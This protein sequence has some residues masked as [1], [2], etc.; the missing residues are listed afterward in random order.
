MIFRNTLERAQ[1]SFIAQRVEVNKA[2]LH[3]R[4]VVLLK[5]SQKSTWIFVCPV[6]FEVGVSSVSYS[7]SEW[8]ICSIE[9]KCSYM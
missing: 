9:Q 1:Q 3:V 5:S 4:S 2:F 7:T 6:T 8:C